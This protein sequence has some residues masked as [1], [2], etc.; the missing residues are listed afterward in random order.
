MRS[1][2]RRMP[3]TLR[4]GAAVLATAAAVSAGL[5]AG[6]AAALKVTKVGPAPVVLPAG[7]KVEVKA[8]ASGGSGKLSVVLSTSATSAKGGVLL[9]GKGAKVPAKGAKGVAVKGTLP[10]TLPVGEKRFVLVC[11]SAAKAL[12]GGKASCKSAGQ[13]PISGSGLSDRLDAAR[14]AGRLT[15]GKQ[16]LYALQ[17]LARDPRLPAELAGATTSTEGTDELI[18][19]VVAASA[20]F[21]KSEKRALIPFF[22]PP[23][24]PGSAWPQAR[25]KKKP[26]KS[27]IV[28]KGARAAASR[29]AVASAARADADCSGYNMLKDSPYTGTWAKPWIAIPTADGKALIW[30]QEGNAAA[31]GSATTY[32]AEFPGI[33]K[34]L[35]AEFG[36]PQS[37][38]GT[39]CYAGPDGRFDVYVDN[40]LTWM[41][42][43]GVGTRGAGH[44]L[45]VTMPYPSASA[46]FC[47][48]RPAWISVK[49]GQ[50]R[51]TLAHEFMHAIQFS[52]TYASCDEPLGWWDEGGANWAA[53]FVYPDDNLERDFGDWAA[54]PL[55]SSDFVWANYRAYPFWMF[56]QRTYGTGVLKSIFAQMKTKKALDAVNAGIPGGF[57]E[58]WPRFALQL[59]NISPI[60]SP[61]F[62]IKESFD[63]WDHW[64]IHPTKP[65][66]PDLVLDGAKEKTFEL[67]IQNAKA[68]AEPLSVAAYHQVFV[69]DDDVREIKF[70]NKLK[71]SG[72]AHVQALLRLKTGEWKLKDWTGNDAVLCRDNPDE[73]VQELVIV[74]TNAG[75]T[76]SIPSFTHELRA[77]DACE[78]PTFR[79][80]GYSDRI[81]S[82]TSRGYGERFHEYKGTP[83]DPLTVDP[84]E[85]GPPCD[86]EAPTTI[87]EVRVLTTANGYVTGTPSPSCPGGRYDYPTQTLDNPGRLAMVF[88]P[89]GETGDA[90]VTMTPP[91]ASVGDVTAGICGAYT[92]GRDRNEITATVKREQVLSGKPFT[93]TLSS[94]N[95]ITSDAFSAS[96]TIDYDWTKT[97]T[98]VR[99]NEDGSAYGS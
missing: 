63:A 28:G 92:T 50:P 20:T 53:D 82:E 5:P 42:A 43:G 51:F 7:A 13:A 84:C 46:T 22:A 61:G 10:T 71:G 62:P 91:I 56:L 11:A 49:A 18:R 67:P 57:A 72:P 97:V 35:T 4:L 65:P 14:A 96:P 24:A 98:M 87:F 2:T 15:A 68:A 75:P 52:H 95:T 64:P 54:N 94:A 86:V 89:R 25:T 47:T 29:A 3:P 39:D 6:A 16:A 83:G 37:D 76:G 90:K 8:S 40:G 99:V 58:Q 79:I 80:I 78:R 33:W 85:F 38:K 27:V 12:T 26:K 31:K 93:F 21:S 9:T 59:W 88:D 66:S 19:S 17:A 30:Y 81:V 23:S 36:E 73:D 70:T 60:G 77:R 69:R 44:T 74:S 55:G 41:A 34:K 45:G 48:N 32:A 1:P